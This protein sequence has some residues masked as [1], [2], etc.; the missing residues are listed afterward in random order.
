MIHRDQ[1]MTISL[2]R[3]DHLSVL[4]SIVY[5]VTLILSLLHLWEIVGVRKTLFVRLTWRLLLDAS[6]TSFASQFTNAGVKERSRSHWPTLTVTSYLFQN[7]N[8]YH[9]KVWGKKN[10]YLLGSR[11][12]SDGVFAAA[13]VAETLIQPLQ[14]TIE[15]HLHPAR[16][17]GH[18][19]PGEEV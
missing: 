18:I 10:N 12:A 4:M 14:G 19:L 6:V 5:A 1:L 2:Y 7:P 11:H 15:G 3:C 13:H 17:T 16:S 9:P 8:T